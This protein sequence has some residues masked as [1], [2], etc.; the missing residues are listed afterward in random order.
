MV[1]VLGGLGGVPGALA[2][3]VALGLT[4]GLVARFVNPGL[5]LAALYLL[6]LGAVLYLRGNREV[7]RQ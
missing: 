7:A 6:F 5:S 2:G 3:G 1:V 4:E